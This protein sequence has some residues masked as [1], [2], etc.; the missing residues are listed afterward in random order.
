MRGRK[1]TSVAGRLVVR[2]RRFHGEMLTVDEGKHPDKSQAWST[3]GVNKPDSLQRKLPGKW[4]ATRGLS[5]KLDPFFPLIVDGVVAK[6]QRAAFVNC[7]WCFVA[8][9]A[10]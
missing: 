7:R 9:E 4:G 5:G 1:Y 6:F 3:Q 2:L 10:H 8:Q